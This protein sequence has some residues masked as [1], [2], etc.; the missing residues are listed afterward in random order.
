[1]KDSVKFHR[2]IIAPAVKLFHLRRLGNSIAHD[3]TKMCMNIHDSCLLL[4]FSCNYVTKLVSE[5]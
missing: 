2:S 3:V 1:M 5:K 4:Y